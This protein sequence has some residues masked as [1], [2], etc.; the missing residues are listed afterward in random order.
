MISV[1]ASQKFTYRI[2]LVV[3]T[4]NNKVYVGQTRRELSTR[5]Y[6]HVR[7]TKW[8]NSSL[9]RAIRKY[10]PEVFELSELS[11]A[12][13]REKANELE[14]LWIWALRAAYGDSGYNLSHT[15]SVR[16]LNEES[17]KKLSASLKGVRTWNTG[18][19]LPPDLA[20]RHAKHIAG[21]FK[22]R[23]HTDASKA[24]M[25]QIRKGTRPSALA[26]A[27]SAE[28]RRRH[29]VSSNVVQQLFSMGMPQ[30]EIAKWLKCSKGLIQDRLRGSEVYEYTR[31]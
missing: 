19:K 29:D 2:Y 14:T 27:K 7:T 11:S 4:T 15:G 18:I 9:T 17:R 1:D 30:F 22:G 25:R 24:L 20:A 21:L 13:S 26:L 28:L 12:T 16:D 10:G 8:K 6:E 31:I 3:N 5:W 23:R